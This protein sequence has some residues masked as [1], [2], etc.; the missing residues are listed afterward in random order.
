MEE[1]Q[2]KEVKEEEGTAPVAPEQ[3]VSAAPATTPVQPEVQPVQQPAPQQ[4]AEI[5]RAHV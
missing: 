2:K 4:P 1:E 3:P 5:G